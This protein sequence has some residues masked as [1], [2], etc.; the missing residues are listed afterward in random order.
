MLVLYYELGRLGWSSFAVGHPAVDTRVETTRYAVAHYWGISDDIAQCDAIDGYI[1]NGIASY[2][3]FIVIGRIAVFTRWS[4]LTVVSLGAG[5]VGTFV[6]SSTDG[7]WLCMWISLVTWSTFAG[8]TRSGCIGRAWNC[9]DT[10][11]WGGGGA[12]WNRWRSVNRFARWIRWSS[13]VE[14][15]WIGFICVTSVRT[16]NKWSK[17]LVVKCH[18]DIVVVE[19]FQVVVGRF[20]FTIRV[21]HE[22]VTVGR[23]NWKLAT[24]ITAVINVVRDVTAAV[25]VI[26]AVVA[27]AV[28][29]A[30]AVVIG[31]HCRD[32]VW[33]GT[34]II[35]VVINWS[36]TCGGRSNVIGSSISTMNRVGNLTNIRHT[37]MM[38]VWTIT[39]CSD[40]IN[41]YSYWLFIIWMMVS[42]G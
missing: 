33:I 29:V 40:T 28:A 6:W 1:G 37:L 39:N 15:W 16:I 34:W 31:I 10:E 27:V 23:D 36:V 2:G 22:K 41:T 7:N 13:F 14:N 38:R 11:G 3:V 25:V 21:K 24:V 32:G 18:H 8:D 12:G 30:V 4:A 9:I 26:V 19:V 42:C 35:M 5:T 17:C 20:F